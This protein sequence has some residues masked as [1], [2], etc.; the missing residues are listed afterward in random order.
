MFGHDAL[1]LAVTWSGLQGA[2]NGDEEQP[3]AFLG[4]PMLR[5]A[6]AQTKTC[7]SPATHNYMGD[8]HK[9]RAI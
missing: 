1:A 7:K 9:W 8:H 3:T 6:T 2:I 4:F 5:E